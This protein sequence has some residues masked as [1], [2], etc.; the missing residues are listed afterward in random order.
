MKW[1]TPLVELVRDDVGAA[2]ILGP[3]LKTVIVPPYTGFLVK[4]DGWPVGAIILNCFTGADI[5]LTAAMRRGFAGKSVADQIARYCFE[6]LGVVRITART[7]RSNRAAIIGLKLC[8]F[9]FESIAADHFG[10][11]DAIVMARLKRH[12]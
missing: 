4:S 2:S 8:K 6:E 11:E 5:A 12:E 9:R 1:A 10:D 7:R 3:I